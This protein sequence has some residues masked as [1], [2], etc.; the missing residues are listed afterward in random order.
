MVFLAHPIYLHFLK[1][2]SWYLKHICWVITWKPKTDQRKKQI[3]QDDLLNTLI[4]TIRLDD[5][6]PLSRL[7]YLLARKRKCL[8]KE[9]CDSCCIPNVS[10]KNKSKKLF[11]DFECFLLIKVPF[12]WQTTIC[13]H[14]S[15]KIKAAIPFSKLV[16]YVD[17][18]VHSRMSILWCRQRTLTVDVLPQPAGPVKSNRFLPFSWN[19]PLQAWHQQHQQQKWN[20]KAVILPLKM[21]H[22][23]TILQL[24]I[25]SFYEYKANPTEI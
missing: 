2:S 3:K 15:A 20:I 6:N 19:V 23:T 1:P 12:A 16:V 25:L 9:I 14:K 5:L 7:E 4:R 24:P 22:D 13:M 10:P 11:R 18:F 17:G 8:N 21:F